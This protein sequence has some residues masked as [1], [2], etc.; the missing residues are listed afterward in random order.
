MICKKSLHQMI[1]TGLILFLLTRVQWFS[2]A[3]HPLPPSHTPLPTY[4][5]TPTI[6][7]EPTSSPTSTPVPVP[8][9]PTVQPLVEYSAPI[10]QITDQQGIVTTVKVDHRHWRCGIGSGNICLARI[11]ALK[12]PTVSTCWLNGESFGVSMQVKEGMP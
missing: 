1:G 8:P 4:T 7:P 11:F 6:T 10:V 9:M 2:C 12:E 3:A 5:F